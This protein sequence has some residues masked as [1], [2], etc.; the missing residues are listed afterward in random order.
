MEVLLWLNNKNIYNNKIL[1]RTG[2]VKDGAAN[3]YAVGNDD[4]TQS[5]AWCDK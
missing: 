1:D 2:I 3:I 5:S 4:Y